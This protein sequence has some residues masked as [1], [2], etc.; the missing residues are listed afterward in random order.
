ML[1]RIDLAHHV[2][3]LLY[4]ASLVSCWTVETRRSTLFPWVKCKDATN[5]TTNAIGWADECRCK[6][7]EMYDVTVHYSGVSK[8][9]SVKLPFIQEA[10]SLAS[11]LWPS[12][13]AGAILSA[14]PSFRRQYNHNTSILELGAGLGLAGQVLSQSIQ[15]K[16]CVL[17]DKNEET[18]TLLQDIIGA[19]ANNVL[20][21]RYLEWRDIPST[22]DDE[23][24]SFDVVLGTDVAYYYFLLRP[25]LNT[26]QYFMKQA[27]SLLMIVGQA[28]RE[29]QWDLY[30]IIHK[31][32]YNQETDQHEDAWEGTT[33]MLLYQLAMS[34]WTQRDSNEE[35]LTLDDDPPN[36]NDNVKGIIPIAVLVHSPTPAL[37]EDGSLTEWDHVATEADR[38]AM[39]ISF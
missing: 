7:K 26:I 39:A 31:G 3:L 37:L 27:H 28:N 17:T 33:N 10:D 21:S 1:L 38:E 36:L 19:A 14:S 13:L 34:E 6:E 2:S 18:V 30:D 11:S 15:A 32:G 16:K 5:H 29:S 20:E 8:P 4:I 23:R 24:H 9:I 35:E 22:R 25:L 12:G